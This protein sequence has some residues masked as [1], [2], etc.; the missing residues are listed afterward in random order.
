M[1]KAAKFDAFL[2]EN[3]I[4]CFN[5]E[6]VKNDLHTVVYRAHMEVSGQMLPTMVVADDSIY[7]M[8]QVRVAASVVNEGNKQAVLEHINANTKY[9]N[10]ML[11]ITAISAWTAALPTRKKAL[12]RV[13]Y[14]P[15]LM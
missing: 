15:L 12:T 13:L 9:L 4:T 2:A 5:K 3:K 1:T 8:I 10:I 6:E 7:T 14:I 11:P